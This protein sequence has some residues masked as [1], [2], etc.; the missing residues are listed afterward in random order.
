MF[1]HCKIKLQD[2]EV[3]VIKDYFQ[4][5]F[6]TIQITKAAFRELLNTQFEKKSD[7]AEARKALYDIK[8]KLETTKTTV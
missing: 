3:K 8:H 4:N 1:Q 6:K 5:K 7:A 2:D